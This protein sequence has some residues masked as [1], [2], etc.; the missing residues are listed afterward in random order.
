MVLSGEGL[1]HILL[2]HPELRMI[3]GLEDVLISAV[4]A[5]DFIVE[6][7]HGEHIAV[8]HVPDLP[9]K[10]KFLIV[11]YDEGGEVRTAFVTSKPHKIAERGIIWRR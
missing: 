4:K 9:L 10:A 5:P 8:R 3:R 2:R 11:A 1:S 7:E 6:G